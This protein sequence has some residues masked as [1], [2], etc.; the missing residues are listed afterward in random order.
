MDALQKAERERFKQNIRDLGRWLAPGLGIK[1]WFLVV[2]LVSHWS[3]RACCSWLSYVTWLPSGDPV[4][5]TYHPS[6]LRVS[7]V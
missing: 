4:I 1:R 5:W 2:L 7:P 6:I 3:V